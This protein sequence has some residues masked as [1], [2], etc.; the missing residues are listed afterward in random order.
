MQLAYCFMISQWH[1]HFQVLHVEEKSL[2]RIPGTNSEGGIV[3]SRRL[4]ACVHCACHYYRINIL[5]EII[6]AA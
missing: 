3:K 4:Y 6:K 1:K 2:L 5:T